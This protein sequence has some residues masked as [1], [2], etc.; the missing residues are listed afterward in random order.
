MVIVNLASG[1]IVEWIRLEGFIAELFDV[2]AMPGVR[3]P[4]AVGPDS[5]EMQTTISFEPT[6]APL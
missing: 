5:I 2:V 6:I 3:C 1:D 4:M